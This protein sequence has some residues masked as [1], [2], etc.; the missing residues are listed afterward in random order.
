MEPAGRSTW[1]GSLGCERCD[2]VWRAPSQGRSH[3][4]TR[5]LGVKFSYRQILASAV[6][7]VLAA[8]IASVF[9]VKG[10]IVG[11]AIGSIVATTGTGLAFKSIEKTNKAVKQVVVRAPESSLLRRLGGTDAAGL[12]EATPLESSAST[13]ETGTSAAAAP[14]GV[15]NADTFAPAVTQQL[16]ASSRDPDGPRAG[17]ARPGR[18]RR[19]PVRDCPL[20][21]RGPRRLRRLRR[22]TALRHGRRARHRPTAGRPFRSRWWGHHGGENLREPDDD[23]AAP[24]DD[25]DIHHDV[26]VVD[27]LDVALRRPPPIRAPRPRS[28]GAPPR[29]PAS[30]PPQRRHPPPPR[31][32]RRFRAPSRR[33]RAGRRT[34]PVRPRSREWGV[35]GTS[36]GVP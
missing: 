10:T 13:E 11:V 24:D 27:D 12:T 33:N 35:A 2:I 23:P 30:D 31:P 25:D 1:I 17:R 18:S 6:G 34:R 5:S 29:R 3:E 15:T 26:D 8:V 9:G 32:R 14:E 4:T 16:T 36:P 20:A 21:G 7:A 28:G 19:I 22:L